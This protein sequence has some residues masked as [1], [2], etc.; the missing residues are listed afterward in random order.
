MAKAK[1]AGSAG[2]FPKQN[3]L[4]LCIW[5]FAHGQL[6]STDPAV[7][8]ALDHLTISQTHATNFPM[9]F[10]EKHGVQLLHMPTTAAG[11]PEAR[12]VPAL[13]EGRERQPGGARPQQGSIRAPTFPKCRAH[14]ISPSEL[15][16]QS[17]L[18]YMQTNEVCGKKNCKRFVIS[19]VFPFS[20]SFPTEARFL[21]CFALCVCCFLLCFLFFFFLSQLSGEN[22]DKWKP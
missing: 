15:S 10:P 2:A 21:F 9:F 5:G 13:P 6:N 8:A 14:W 16:L 18:S 17:I 20:H 12:A 22:P 3:A 1:R 4:S 19:L 11:V 7:Q